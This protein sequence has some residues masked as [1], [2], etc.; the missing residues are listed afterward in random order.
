MRVVLDTNLLVAARISSQGAPGTIYRAWQSGGFTLVTSE[1]QLDEFR[2]VSRYGRV[3]RYIRPA[4]AGKLVTGLKARAQVIDKL[5]ALDCSP[6]PDDNNVLAMAV[7]GRA[8]YLVTGDKRDLLVLGK[9]AGTQI[10]KA[11]D[12]LDHVLR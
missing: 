9:L 6:D 4:E 10:L 8:D 3:K 12:F 2:R 5:P 7:V 11:R 1:W